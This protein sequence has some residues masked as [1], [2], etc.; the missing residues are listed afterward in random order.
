MKSTLLIAAVAATLAAGGALAQTGSPG[1]GS[2]GSGEPAMSSDFS[3]PK[4]GVKGTTG[5][6]Q[7]NTP[8]TQSANGGGDPQST[9]GAGGTSTKK[10]KKSKKSRKANAS[11]GS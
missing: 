2:T 4:T 10:A 6:A 9:M 7:A 8:R 11:Q 1:G 5:D 3:V